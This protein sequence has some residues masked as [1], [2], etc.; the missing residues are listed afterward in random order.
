MI[1]GAGIPSVSDQDVLND[2]SPLAVT[3]AD[4]DATSAHLA[5]HL[6]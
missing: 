1:S 6:L 4:G 2:I 3:L 5:A